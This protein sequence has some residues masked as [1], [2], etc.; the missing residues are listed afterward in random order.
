MMFGKIHLIQALIFPKKER[1]LSRF[2][3]RWIFDSKLIQLFTT[4][5][6]EFGISFLHMIYKMTIQIKGNPEYRQYL[7][8]PI[9]VNNMKIYVVTEEEDVTSKLY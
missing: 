3:G 2:E 7:N 4:F 6:D 9:Y 8:P 1:K 5:Y